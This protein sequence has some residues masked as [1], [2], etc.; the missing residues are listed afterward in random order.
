[1]WRSDTVGDKNRYREVIS[2]K[3][4]RCRDVI[5]LKT[6]MWKGDIRCEGRGT[7]MWYRRKR[8]YTEAQYS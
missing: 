4:G 3:K 2:P 1:M 5:S 8:R 6:E 7:E